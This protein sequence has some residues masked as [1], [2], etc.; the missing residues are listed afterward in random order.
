MI[1]EAHIS[2]SGFVATQPFLRETRTGIPTLTMRVAW[3]PRR[4]DR[5][6]GEWVDGDTSFASVVCFRRLA[7]NT[8]TC[9]R[10]G[11]PVVIRGRLSTRNYEDRNGVQRTNVDIDAASIGHDLSRGVAT[12]QRLRPQT[13]TTAAEYQAAADGGEP[14][15]NPA[16]P[17]DA[18]ADDAALDRLLAS[19]GSRPAARAGSVAGPDGPDSPDGPEQGRPGD[20]DFDADAAD[21]LGHG[22]EDLRTEGA[23]TVAAPF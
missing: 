20:G 3:T 10:K 22:G 21:E 7:E 17:G 23:V 8:A 16:R 2:L 14:A 9:L 19:A 18:A 11:D 5:V 15:A 4:L 13:G 12:F 6:T 1:N